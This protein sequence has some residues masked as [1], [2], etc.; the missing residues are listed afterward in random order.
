MTGYHS[1]VGFVKWDWLIFK[2]LCIT[3]LNEKPGDV[4][5]PE[6][7]DPSWHN[8]VVGCLRCQKKCPMNRD[9]ISSLENEVTF[10]QVET[11]QILEGTSRDDLPTET[12]RKLEELCLINYLNELPRNLSALFARHK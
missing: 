11:T 9:R 5:F 12:T 2:S 3:F 10:S 6:W 4:P 1:S 7:V 8:C